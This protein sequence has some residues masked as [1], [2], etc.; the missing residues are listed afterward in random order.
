MVVVDWIYLAQQET[1]KRFYLGKKKVPIGCKISLCG[2]LL[3]GILKNE[4]TG[5]MQIT[6]V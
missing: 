4:V 5:R 6:T 1:K 3:A 2:K